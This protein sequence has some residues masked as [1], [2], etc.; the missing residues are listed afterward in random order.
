MTPEEQEQHEWNRAKERREAQKAEREQMQFAHDY[1]WGARQVKLL[2]PFFLAIIAA[3]QA[4]LAWVDHGDKKVREELARSEAAARDNATR[5]MAYAQ[6]NLMWAHEVAAQHQ[7]LSS[8]NPS[9]VCRA[10]ETLRIAAP[11]SIKASGE[12]FFQQ[13]I[14]NLR[15]D[16]QMCAPEELKKAI[17]SYKEGLWGPFRLGATSPNIR[18]DP[19]TRQLFSHKCDV[20]TVTNAG[21][22]SDTCKLPDG[23]EGKVYRVEY[24]CADYKCGWSYG[25][26]PGNYDQVVELKDREIVWHR[27]WGG[28]AHRESYI[29]YYEKPQSG[30]PPAS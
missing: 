2:I 26:Q 30:E 13:N 21:P 8:A 22:R 18:K 23:V 15:V 1:A 14:A 28:D 9:D 17:A 16:A 29:M 11:P 7:L 20:D 24:L 25:K 5:S 6:M 12:A 4:Y 27:I 3:C 19:V 10:V